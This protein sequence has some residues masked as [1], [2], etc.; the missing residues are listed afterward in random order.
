MNKKK[1]TAVIG[2]L[3]VCA[4]ALGGLMLMRRVLEQRQER[5]LS[6]TGTIAAEN[7]SDE[8]N[9]AAATQ[10]E[11]SLDELKEILICLEYGSQEELQEPSGNQISMKTA[12]T[13]GQQWINT[14]CQENIEESFEVPKTYG[15]I[16]ATLCRKYFDTG[17]TVDWYK[18]DIWADTD[19][20]LSDD[21][22]CY[23]KME[24]HASDTI[25]ALWL[26]AVTG[27]VLRAKIVSYEPEADF[28]SSD[29]EKIL[30]SYADSF[31][32]KGKYSLGREEIKD[33]ATSKALC[34]EEKELYAILDTDRIILN[35]SYDGK[36]SE[37]CMNT[38]DLYLSTEYPDFTTTT[39]VQSR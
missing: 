24:Y 30:I 12:I 10:T 37:A 1:F 3:A 28:S 38:L 14:F 19:D 9:E 16:T 39:Q 22:L 20:T 8:K 15:K 25:I 13:K 29:R 31:A 34:F 23:W 5:L 32:L 26:N 18:E 35:S 7:A 2:V 6:Q 21:A 17:S 11:L 33:C 27:Q 4:V 36:E